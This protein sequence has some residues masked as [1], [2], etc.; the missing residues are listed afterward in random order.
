MRTHKQYLAKQ[1][2]NKAFAEGYPCERA[3]LRVAYD[4]HSARTRLGL[5]QKD[6]ARKAGVTQQMVSRVEN[7]V[8]ANMSQNT[9]CR[10]AD[11]LGMDIGLVAK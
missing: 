2:E 5:S 4:I 10:I 11:A 7:A 3:K 1:L 9:V 6:L 8:V